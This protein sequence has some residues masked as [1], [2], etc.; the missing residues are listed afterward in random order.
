MKN[1]VM[2]ASLL[3]S[4]NLFARNRDGTA[5][6]EALN[7]DLK[8][9]GSKGLS[10]KLAIDSKEVSENQSLVYRVSV[11]SEE[12]IEEEIDGVKEMYPLES[13]S[14]Y[15]LKMDSSNCSLVEDIKITGQAG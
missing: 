14:Q 13:W 4:F 8:G 2:I 15:E 9:Y 7:A 6:T 5:Q 10:V 3:C 1:L 12:L 11:Y